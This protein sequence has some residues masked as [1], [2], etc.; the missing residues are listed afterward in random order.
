MAATETGTFTL[1]KTMI[2]TKLKLTAGAI[3]VAG[4]AAA[5]FVH[6]QQ[7]QTHLRAENG[8][9]L[10]QIAQLQTDNESLSNHV[11]EMA[12]SQKLSADQFNELLRL[13]G[14]VGALRRQAG[15]VAQLRNQNQRLQN[16]TT[17]L[18]S[19]NNR[20][21]FADSVAKFTADETQMVNA[22]KQ[23][24]LANRIYA[25][26]NNEQYATNFDQMTN[27]L[28]GLV[29]NGVLDYVEFVNTGVANEHIPQMITFRERTARQ[30]PDGT[31]HRV[32][33]LADGSVQTAVST[34][35]NFNAYE[36]YDANAKGTIYSPQ[37]Q[38][39]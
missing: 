8:S 4:V 7:I 12:D 23:I 16:A 24:G 39:Q 25:G 29:Y 15:E 13:R 1:L 33:G 5:A 19:S 28:G 37:N 35:D 32:Y 14:E 6:Q 17:Q 38:N 22:M 2:A 21:Q 11:S 27:E 20:M 10:Q 34:D 31:W 18:Q 36:R 3:A 26:D 30:S 9:L